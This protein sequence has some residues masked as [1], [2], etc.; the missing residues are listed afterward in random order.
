MKKYIKP[1]I[2]SK[3]YNTAPVLQTAS[4]PKGETEVPGGSALSKGGSNL[5][6]Y[7][8]EEE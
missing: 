5:W 8:E 7:M 3:I 2:V 4:M 6:E 1:S